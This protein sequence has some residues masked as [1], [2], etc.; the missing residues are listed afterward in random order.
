ML[1][2]RKP[3]SDLAVKPE[4]EGLGHIR[5]MLPR[6]RCSTGVREALNEALRP[7]FD[8]RD[9]LH[10]SGQPVRRPLILRLPTRTRGFIS[11]AGFTILRR[12]LAPSW[13]GTNLDLNAGSMRIGP[14]CRAST[15]PRHSRATGRYHRSDWRST[16]FTVLPRMRPV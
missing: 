15:L 6:L 10:S 3:L 14:E 7:R 4:E 11:R 2:H 12:S 13:S 1:R 8:G 5:H 9:T 16:T